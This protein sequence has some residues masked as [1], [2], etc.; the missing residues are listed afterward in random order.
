MKRCFEDAKAEAFARFELEDE[1]LRVTR[2]ALGTA[3]ETTTIE[4]AYAERGVPPDVLLDALVAELPETFEEV[5]FDDLLEQVER[6]H[7]VTLAGRLREFYTRH[8]Y[9][10]YQGMRCRGLDCRVSFVAAAAQG[11]FHQEYYDRAA[12]RAIQLVPVSSKL[13]GKDY[14]YEDEQQWI[15]V[16]P[17]QS[18]G[19][20][21]ALY[22]SGSFE[23]AYDNLDAFLADLE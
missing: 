11:R 8:Q 3:G 1:T 6:G 17:R 5:M 2:G 13:V 4:D 9:K 22:T 21:Y 15:G 19:P 10:R 7:G 16:D 14:R 12:G 23:R 18:D 20:V